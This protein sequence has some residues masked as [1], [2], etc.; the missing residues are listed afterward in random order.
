[1][2]HLGCIC[3]SFWQCPLCCVLGLAARSGWPLHLDQMKLWLLLRIYV[4]VTDWNLKE[5]PGMFLCKFC[6]FIILSL[7]H[8]RGQKTHAGE[9]EEK[10]PVKQVFPVF[11]VSFQYHVSLVSVCVSSFPLSLHSLSSFRSFPLFG[12]FPPPSYSLF[13]LQLSALESITPASVHLYL[14]DLHGPRWNARTLR[15]CLVWLC[16]P[17]NRSSESQASWGYHHGTPVPPTS[18]G[19]CCSIP[20]PIW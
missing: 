19:P 9:R 16:L 10:A 18:T 1:M 8:N 4:G 14:L 3:C 5:N 2:N 20:S 11:F 15:C 7:T 6:D 17:M 13:A 12:I